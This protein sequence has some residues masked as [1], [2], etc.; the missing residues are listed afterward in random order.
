MRIVRLC[1]DLDGSAAG[2]I[3][4]LFFLGRLQHLLAGGREF[5]GLLGE[6]GDDPPAARGEFLQY[7]S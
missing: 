2:S 3:F 4:F 5:G 6:A 7:F 1:A